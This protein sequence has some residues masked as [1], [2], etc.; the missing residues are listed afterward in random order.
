MSTAAEFATGWMGQ[1]GRLGRGF[2]LGQPRAA[3]TPRS[4]AARRWSR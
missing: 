2:T 1:S 4:A 3:V